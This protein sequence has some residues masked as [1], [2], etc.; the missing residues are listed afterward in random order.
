VAETYVRTQV[1]I[2]CRAADLPED[3]V[4]HTVWHHHTTI[5]G[6][7]G[8]FDP[9]G[10]AANV[11]NAFKTGT[12]GSTPFSFYQGRK[13]TAKVYDM[14]AMKPRP[15]LAENIYT[16]ASYESGIFGPR[17]LAIPLRYYADRNLPSQRGRLYIGPWLYTYVQ[18][19]FDTAG[20][21]GRLLD[22]AT[23]LAAIGG[24]NMSW[25]MHSEKEDLLNAPASPG[26]TTVAAWHD[27][28]YAWVNDQWAHMVSREKAE[29]SRVHVAITPGIP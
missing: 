24:A 15:V 25:C 11:I 27:I 1:E 14:A 23:A 10:H 17:E 13:M 16:P 21:G 9:A 4:V 29:A 22:L 8:P 7:A 2:Q 3:F 26:G 20:S 28:T 5:G 19:P 6:I 18:D 12:G